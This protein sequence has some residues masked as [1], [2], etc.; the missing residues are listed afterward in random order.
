M[1][2]INFSGH[3]VAGFEIAPFV[4]A[5]LPAEASALAETVRET[6]LSLPGREELLRGESA[7]IILPGLAHAAGALLAEWHGQFGSFPTIRYAVRGESGFTWPDEAVLNL[8]DV[9]ES[10]RTAR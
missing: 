4:G 6:L 5:N 7:E 1:K 10:A 2:K 3:P 9:R 8:A